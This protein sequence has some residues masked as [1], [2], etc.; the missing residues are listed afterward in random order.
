MVLVYPLPAIG[1][2]TVSY[3]TSHEV[4]YNTDNQLVIIALI[5]PYMVDGDKGN[6]GKSFYFIPCPFELPIL[7]SHPGPKVFYVWGGLCLCALVYSYFL[8]PETKGLTLEQVDQMLEQATPRTSAKWV[9]TETFASQMGYKETTGKHV[10][11]V[12]KLSV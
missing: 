1:S 2:G 3:N 11:D 7:T 8:V 12:E 5:T 6:L 10:E 4:P 9:P